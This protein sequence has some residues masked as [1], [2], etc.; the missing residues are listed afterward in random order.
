MRTATL[1]MFL[2]SITLLGA[3]NPAENVAEEMMENA[4]EEETGGDADVNFGNDGTMRV[5]TDEG[6]FEAGGNR[7]PSDWPSDA[8]VYPGAKVTYSAMM[9]PQTGEP[10]AALM[11]STEDS[12]EDVEAFY[13][14]QI[15]T[16]GWKVEGT[17]RSGGM[18][19][20]TAK[21]EGRVLSLMITAANGQ[22]SITIG[23]GEE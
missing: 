20:I 1:F 11:L 22:T 8:P 16:D 7:V 2:C 10:G 4:I 3:C 18:T 17:M 23:L 5:E 21:K 19:V 15:A 12:E 13:T 6:T 9:N 14:A